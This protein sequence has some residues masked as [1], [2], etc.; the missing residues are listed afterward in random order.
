MAVDGRSR[1]ARRNVGVDRT[2]R[3]GGG[4]MAEVLQALLD[5]LALERIEATGAFTAP[6]VPDRVG[7][8]RSRRSG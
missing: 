5:L 4:L 1:H 7:P 3:A 6:D 8:T 2:L